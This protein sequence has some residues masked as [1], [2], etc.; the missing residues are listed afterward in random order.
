MSKREG[1]GRREGRE[2]GEEACIFMHVRSS[3]VKEVQQKKKR[4]IKTTKKK[5]ASCH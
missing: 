1:K 4:E 2:A 5:A 3:K